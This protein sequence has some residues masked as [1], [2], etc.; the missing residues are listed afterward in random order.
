MILKRI[1]I[2][3]TFAIISWPSLE[4]E[5][6]TVELQPSVSQTAFPVKTG[7]VNDFEK[8]FTQEE[9]TFLENALDYYKRTSNREVIV[10]TIDS[11]PQNTTFDHYALAISNNW[12]VGEAT[13]G[14][15]LTLLLSKKL[16]K[17]RISTTDKTSYYL[18]DE[19]IK[20]VIDE[21]MIPEFKNDRYND[22]LLLGLNELIRKWI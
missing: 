20:K 15:G 19:F 1:I 8:L 14:N 11:L 3:L 10:I 9:I 16:R 6:Q 17:I 12:N 4:V 21:T 22:G 2:L 13:E 5:A 18:P 7:F